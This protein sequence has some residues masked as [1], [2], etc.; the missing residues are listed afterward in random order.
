MPEQ[1]EVSREVKNKM[2]KNALGQMSMTKTM[3]LVLDH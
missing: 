3:L 2:N 1:P